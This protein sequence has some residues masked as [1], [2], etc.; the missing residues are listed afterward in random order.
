MIVEISNKK[1]NYLNN[2]GLLHGTKLARKNSIRLVTTNDKFSYNVNSIEDDMR[3]ERALRHSLRHTIRT[4]EMIA[5]GKN[6]VE[7][8][9]LGLSSASME[10]RL[11]HEQ[12]RWEADL[13]RTRTRLE[14]I[15]SNTSRLTSAAGSTRTISGRKSHQQRRR[16][17]GGVKPNDLITRISSYTSMIGPEKD[18][19]RDEI[20]TRLTSARLV[21]FSDMY[22]HAVREEEVENRR[23]R[24]V[25]RSIRRP[26]V[27]IRS[28]DLETSVR[29]L[30]SRAELCRLRAEAEFMRHDRN[31]R[32]G[33]PLPPINL[34][35]QLRIMANNEA[36]IR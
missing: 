3:R 15:E 22:E 9:R 6:R 32:Y 34:F 18:L 20:R 2:L 5:L 23:R 19:K 33:D 28:V 36:F 16:R 30:K 31:V 7:E 25:F 35:R 24:G 11:S 29:S 21:E 27:V 17:V 12:T 13:A 26:L 10:K 1:E 4:S 14:E 8:K